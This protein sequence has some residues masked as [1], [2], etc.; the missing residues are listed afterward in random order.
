MARVSATL[1]C[2]EPPGLSGAAAG[3]AGGGL[4]APHAH[5]SSAKLLTLPK[6]CQEDKCWSRGWQGSLSMGQPKKL[7]HPGQPS[8]APRPLL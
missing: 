4:R 2:R 7:G 1:G 3:G 8:L 6:T 5:V